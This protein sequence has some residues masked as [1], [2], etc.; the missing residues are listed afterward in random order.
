MKL[1]TELF[2]SGLGWKQRWFPTF[3]DYSGT[4]L[5][6]RSLISPVTHRA[7]GL[8]LPDTG[9]T[10]LNQSLANPVRQANDIN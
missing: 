1:L 10:Q 3:H 4:A 6:G 2:L 5:I 9:P 8:L 7:S